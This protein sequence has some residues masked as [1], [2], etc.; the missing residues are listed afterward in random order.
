MSEMTIKQA[1]AKWK[2]STNWVRELVKSGRVPSKLTGGPVK[3]YAIPA[4]TPK[5]PSMQRSPARKGTSKK[6][7]P[8]SIARREYRAKKAK[9][10]RKVKR[11]VKKVAAKKSA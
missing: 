8:E 1:A 5:P 7:K 6:I 9:A 3:Y 11:A 10:P 2:I 4:G